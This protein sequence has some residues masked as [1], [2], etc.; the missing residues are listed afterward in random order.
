MNLLS[1]QIDPVQRYDI[2][3][4]HLLNDEISAVENNQHLEHTGMTTQ[5]IKDR[6]M[7]H[8]SDRLFNRPAAALSTHTLPKAEH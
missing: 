8:K 4:F 2:S 1:P 7:E 3:S 5:K 6:I